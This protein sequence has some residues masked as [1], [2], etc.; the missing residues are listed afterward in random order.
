MSSQEIICKAIASMSL[1]RFHYNLTDDPGTRIVEP[2]MVALNENDNLALSAWFVRG[3]SESKEGK[4]WREYLF[5]GI[6]NV[7]IL[8][9]SFSAPRPGYVSTGG[10]KFHNVRCAL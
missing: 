5:T 2:H 3:H 4:G 9:E 8:N 10:Q 6:S 7:V 1:V